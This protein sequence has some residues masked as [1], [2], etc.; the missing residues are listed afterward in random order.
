M[1][2][3]SSLMCMITCV[4]IDIILAFYG[5]ILLLLLFFNT[6]IPSLLLSGCFLMIGCM[7]PYMHVFCIFVFALIQCS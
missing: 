6:N 5:Y 7:L 2:Y 3:N 4:Y 1:R